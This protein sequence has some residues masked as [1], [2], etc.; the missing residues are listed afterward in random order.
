MSRS[1][2][3]PLL[4]LGAEWYTWLLD[5]GATFAWLYPLVVHHVWPALSFVVLHVFPW[6]ALH[7]RLSVPAALAIATKPFL[8]TIACILVANALLQRHATL[9]G[10]VLCCAVLCCAVLC[11][12]VL[13]CAVLCCAVLCCA[14]WRCAVS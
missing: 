13:C 2:T 1:I 10:C 11:C 9:R 6:E 8:A 5:E 3:E 7:E 12:A 4:Q 14:V